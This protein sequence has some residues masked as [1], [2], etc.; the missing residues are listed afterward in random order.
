[1]LFLA[2]AGLSRLREAAL[3][4]RTQRGFEA[5]RYWAAFVAYGR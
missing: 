5:P 3:W 2:A 4:L 1:V